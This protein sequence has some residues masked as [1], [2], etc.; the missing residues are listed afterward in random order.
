MEQPGIKPD[1]H[2]RETKPSLGERVRDLA[3][4]CALVFRAVPRTATVWALAGV[5]SGVLTPLQLWAGGQLIGSIVTG[6]EGPD[7]GSPWIW[8]AI[9]AASQVAGRFLDVARSYMEATVTERGVPTVQA[10]VYAQATAIDL[11]DY[12]HQGF[13]DATA[14]ITNEIETQAATVIRNLQGTFESGP[15]LVGAVILVFGI[16]WRLGLIA[17]LPLVPNLVMW[18]RSGDRMWT[19]LSDQTRDRRLATYYADRMTDRQAAKEIRLFGLQP[20]LLGQWSRHYLATRDELRRKRMGLA[21]RTFS[22][23]ATSSAFT[24]AA[25][26]WLFFGADLQLQAQEITIL[27]SSFLSL[28]NWVFNFAENAAALGQFSGIASDTRAFI[29]RPAP[30]AP[31]NA[32]LCPTPATPESAPEFLTTSVIPHPS[33]IPSISEESPCEAHPT[34]SD[35]MHPQRGPASPGDPSLALRMTEAGS[36]R[37]H[38]ALPGSALQD[39]KRATPPARSGGLLEATGLR[40]AYPGS[41]RMIIDGI[42][43]V[44]PSGQRVAIVGE[45]GAGKTT[46]LKL[47]LGLYEADAGTVALDGVPIRDIPLAQRQR[48]LSAVF[49]QFTRYPLTLAENIQ[50]GSATGS[51]TGSVTGSVNEGGGDRRNLDAVLAMAGMD[52]YVRDQPAGAETVLSP[53]LGGVDLSGGQWQRLA[54]ARAGYRDADVLALDE[55][56]AALDPMAEVDIFRRF[57]QLA[58]GRTALLVSHRLGMARLADRILVIEDGRVV[59]D[60]SHHR[61]RQLNGRYTAMWAMQARWYV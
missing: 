46:L 5:L 60:G 53:D 49:Q 32:V 44:I 24:L 43:L 19:M 36:G 17:L 21:L 6:L 4:L 12:E 23:I 61:L 51:A 52:A 54:I 1:P 18:F 30:F 28:P 45:N 48:R 27:M 59:E 14:R 40:F 22:L 25:L 58:E 35:P 56:T 38:D 39:G 15:R 16:D 7:A 13:Y 34:Q 47:L 57:A 9:L 42:S 50:V 26:A 20:H 3:W 33:V 11:G 8:L 2:L 10:R 55:P 29:G 37:S 31:G 41:E